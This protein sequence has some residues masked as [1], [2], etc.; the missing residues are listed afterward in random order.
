MGRLQKTPG[1]APSRPPA[2][3]PLPGPAPP[4]NPLIPARSV[5]LALAQSNCA[6]AEGSPFGPSG[7]SCTV[8]PALPPPRCRQ[9]FQLLG[10][11]GAGEEAHWAKPPT[12]TCLSACRWAGAPQHGSQGKRL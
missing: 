1:L 4:E 11:L 9:C 7:F 3:G 5:C 8:R 12:P 2:P 6:K 10:V